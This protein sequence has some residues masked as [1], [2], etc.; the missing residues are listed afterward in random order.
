MSKTITNLA[1]ALVDKATDDILKT[2]PEYPHQ[3]VFAS[4]ALRQ[5][6][7]TYVLSRI[8]GLYVVT[9]DTIPAVAPASLPFSKDQQGDIECLIHQGIQH[10]LQDEKFSF[11]EISVEIVMSP[12]Q[13]FG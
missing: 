3:Q 10:I 13:W 8:P 6:L 12:S 7:A 4:A 1:V 11:P 9:N 2:Y 5:R